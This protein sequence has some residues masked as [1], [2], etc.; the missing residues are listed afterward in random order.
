VDRPL[1]TLTERQRRIVLHGTSTIEG[2]VDRV[3]ALDEYEERSATLQPFFTETPC[4]TCQGRRLNPRALAVMVHGRSVAQLTAQSVAECRKDLARRKFK[5]RE[6]AV[7][8]SIMK[9]ILPRLGFL[10]AVGL[11]Y[12]T[13]DRRADTL[14]GGEAQRIRLA[15]QLGSNLRGVCYV[16][17]EPTIGLHPRDN[18]MLLDTLDGLKKRGN[19][20]LVVEHDEDTIRRADLVIDLG[21]GGGTHGGEVVAVAPP[22][23]LA[24]VPQ[25]LTGR[26]LREHRPRRAPRRDL[27]AAPRLT[28]VGARENN[29]RRVRAEFPMGALTCVTGVSGSGKSTL[30]H[31][32][33]YK[34]VRQML[35]HFPG[36]VG[37]HDTITG[38]E[39]IRRVVEVDQSPIGRTPR[40]VPASYVG[41]LGDIRSLFA[42]TPEA[43]MRG[44]GPGRFSFNVQ[45]GRCQACAGQGRLRIEMSFLPDVYVECESCAG[46]RFTDDTLAVTYGGKSIAEVLALTVEEAAAFFAAVPAVARAVT[47]LDDIGLGYLTLGQPSNTL[48]GGEAQRI[49]L[50]AELSRD[51]RGHTLY[52]LDEPTTG[53]HLADTERLIAVLH[54]LCDRG[55]AVVVIEHNLDV[56]KEADHVIDLGPEGG[57][58]GGRVV[59]SGPPLH[60]IRQTSRSHTARYLKPHLHPQDGGARRRAT[61]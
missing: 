46:R 32:V 41:F 15:A 17:D 34:G 7:A 37:T 49:K 50:A 6:G 43:R 10:E 2:L 36:R 51:P 21:P 24:G 42:G 30:V 25:S 13:L 18:R 29:L 48:S 27:R 9:E 14:S 57:M 26:F 45:D 3:L 44:Y 59:A 20:V 38:V 56:I 5:G 22:D 61:G 40:S 8:E 1:R 58:G 39:H 54:R 33:L 31:D 53:L 52:V 35:G 55:H 11:G 16:L 19:T 12:L 28:V 60:I 4:A 47:L 23:G